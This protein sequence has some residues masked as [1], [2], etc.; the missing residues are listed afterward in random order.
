MRLAE[1]DSEEKDHGE[2]MFYG[3]TITP[4]RGGNEEGGRGPDG[5][6][7]MGGGREHTIAPLGSES[8]KWAAV[9][10]QNNAWECPKCHVEQAGRLCTRLSGAVGLHVGSWPGAVVCRERRGQS[11]ELPKV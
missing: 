1:L 10:V 9:P 11:S 2:V 8:W 5:L 6:L 4:F 3:I 7:R